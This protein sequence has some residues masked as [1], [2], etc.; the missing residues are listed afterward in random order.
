VFMVS[1]DAVFHEGVFPFP[2]VTEPNDD[3]PLPIHILDHE[4]LE[5]TTFM[6][7]QLHPKWRQAM[8]DELEALE[9]NNTWE[10]TPLPPD[11]TTIGCRWV[12]KVK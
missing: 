11:K 4:P 9:K 2:E 5:P 7:A 8:T 12:F 3:C 1:R 10:V 6:Q